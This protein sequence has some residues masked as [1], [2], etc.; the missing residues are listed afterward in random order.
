MLLRSKAAIR[1]PLYAFIL[2]V[3]FILPIQSI[4]AID[5]PIQSLDVNGVNIFN[6]EGGYNESHGIAGIFY[7]VPSHTLTM[8]NASVNSI[9]ASGDLDI[10]IIGTNT[11]TAL[12]DSS[13]V[14]AMGGDLTI[15]GDASTLTISS[16]AEGQ[17][18]V[19][20]GEGGRLTVGETGS[21]ITVTVSQGL[22]INCE[23]T[24]VVDG[25]TFNSPASGDP[26]EPLPE[27]PLLIYIGGTLVID[28]TAEPPVTSASGEGWSIEQGFM[29]IYQLTI[30]SGTTLNYITG[31]GDG[32]LSISSTDGNFSIEENEDHR[33]INMN[34]NVM[35]FLGCEMGNANLVGGIYTEGEV[36]ISDGEMIS[37][38]TSEVPSATGI[39]SN[40]LYIGSS[41]LF[42]YTSGTALQYYNENP[43]EGEGMMVESGEG[44]SLTVVSSD[45]ATSNVM[46]VRVSGGGTI[47]LSYTSA[48]GDFTPEA[49]HWPWTDMT[50]T[51]EENPIPT[52]VTC[53]EGTDAAN[54][55]RMTSTEGNFLLE[56]TAGTLYQLG[57]NIPGV[58]DSIVTNGT[59]RVIAANGFR[60]TSGG[61]TDYS[62]EAGSTVTIELLP[63]YGYQYVSGGLNGNQT[64]P[65]VGKGSYT[66]TMPNNNLHLSAIFKRSSDIVTLE[67]EKIEAASLV[68]PDNQI[69]GNA[70]LLVEEAQ[71]V[72]KENF[73]EASNGFE[74]GTYLDLSLNE[75][76][77]KGTTK[78]AWRTNISELEEETT[79]TLTLSD[80]LQ[81][82]AEYTVLREHNGIIEELDAVYDPS[83]NSITF[84]T[85][86]FST[87]ALAY[88]DPDNP[89][90][91]GGILAAVGLSVISISGLSAAGMYS[92]KRNHKQ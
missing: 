60:F 73:E 32:A 54:K 91:Y 28:E 46:S 80:E 3:L 65:G 69:S 2:S 39:S 57:W 47:D 75:L 89:N 38:G 53:E 25:N 51:E 16:V 43:A 10:E 13:A 71:E 1:L 48:L 5:A 33:S 88:N 36:S 4:I 64:F 23:D 61:Y 24:Y 14:L 12:T 8:N 56:S 55:Y 76:V 67:T 74:I 35:I 9:S 49:S 26:V 29:N 83:I 72:K 44:H 22:L 62:I 81:G 34:G 20:I 7:D 11:V 84:D 70:E 52:T 31:T 50:G 40:R 21:A 85:D 45:V 78:E 86:S 6:L 77:F 58:D 30:E 82:H 59:V 41:D 18:A 63:D 66:F 79:I 87:Y 42:I 37:I 27:D 19:T 17:P 92:R 68:M 90:T 15:T